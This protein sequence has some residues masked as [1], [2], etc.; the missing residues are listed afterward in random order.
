MLSVFIGID[1]ACAKRKRLPICFAYQ[2]GK[3]LIP[4]EV[5]VTLARSIPR[6]I[7]NG[8]V[9]DAAPFAELAAV[10]AAASPGRAGPRQCELALSAAGLSVFRTPSDHEWPDLLTSCR[11]HLNG[12]G[13]LARLPHANKIW[14]VYGFEL[15][16][17]LRRVGWP[18]IEV[19]PFAIVHALLQ[20]H[21]HKSTDEGYGM[22]LG[23]I[24]EQTGWCSPELDA[25]LRKTVAGSRH[26]RLDAFMAAWVAG[27][28]THAVTAYG[29]RH[30]L[31]DAIW[32]PI[33]QRREA[34]HPPE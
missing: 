8:A 2:D 14:M 6:G 7:G 15:F 22:Q 10:V 21:P 32:V 27:L 23:A 33:I 18:L 24:A 3:R 9:L 11:Q 28:P 25:L 12:A 17:A 26:D 1:V 4:L 29:N 30:N 13:S 5:P 20:R 31:N 34:R 19:Y 16:S